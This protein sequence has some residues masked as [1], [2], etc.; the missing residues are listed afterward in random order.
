MKAKEVSFSVKQTEVRTRVELST[1]LAVHDVDPS[2][3]ASGGPHSWSLLKSIIG[4]DMLSEELFFSMCC[5]LPFVHS[6][7][8]PKQYPL[9]LYRSK[10]VADWS[11][12]LQPT[13]ILNVSMASSK[14]RWNL[15]SSEST[16]Q[17]LA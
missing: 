13:Q 17:L 6:R 10:L 7:E 2:E 8:I 15:E 12:Q 14:T 1:F 9:G 5:T 4:Q 11:G 3:Y 16:S